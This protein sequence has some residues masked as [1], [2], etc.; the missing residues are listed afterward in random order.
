MKG[1]LNIAVIVAIGVIVADLI[2]PAH[3]GGTNA[4]LKGTGD[5]WSISVR[6]MLGQPSATKAI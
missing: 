5:L 2:Q 4:I 6:G 1:I 3:L